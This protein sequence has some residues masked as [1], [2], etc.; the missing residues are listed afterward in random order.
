MLTLGD[1]GS[2]LDVGVASS[3]GQPILDKAAVRAAWAMSRVN[4]TQSRELILPVI[5]RLD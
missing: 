2:I 5:F 4:W 1:D 3:S